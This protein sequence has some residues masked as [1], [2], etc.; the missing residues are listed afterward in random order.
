MS[1][2]KLC[3]TVK[4]EHKE[5]HTICAAKIYTVHDPDNLGY[6]K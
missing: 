5:F 2:D 4:L 3:Q 6:M 1:R